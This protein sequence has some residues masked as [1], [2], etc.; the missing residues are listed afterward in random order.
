MIDQTMSNIP[1]IDDP[2]S[3]I[4]ETADIPDDFYIPIL[5]TENDDQDEILTTGESSL[6][7]F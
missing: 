1:H 3:N 6:H 4:I 5:N 7:S 2:R